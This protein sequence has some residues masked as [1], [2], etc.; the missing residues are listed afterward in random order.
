MH[1][2]FMWNTHIIGVSENGPSYM[3]LP[4]GN[5]RRMLIMNFA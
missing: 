4:G 5:S 2:L 3:I 1:G